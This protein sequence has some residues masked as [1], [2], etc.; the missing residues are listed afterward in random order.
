M[1]ARAPWREAVTYR[2]T[3]PHEYVVVEKDG[4]Q[5]LLAAFHHRV[6]QGEGVECRF[7]HRTQKYLFLGEYKYWALRGDD[8]VILNRALLYKDRRDFVIREGDT[9]V[10]EVIMDDNSSA[11]EVELTDDESTA[12][13]SGPE[14]RIERLE[15]REA[16][17]DEA[18]DFT[19][20]LA[21]NLDTLGWEL[22]LN[23]ELV[24]TEKAVGSFYLDILA[25][26]VDNG[27]LVAIENQLEWSDHSHLG[28]LLTY[29]AKCE[30]TAAVWIASE[31]RYEHRETINRLNQWTGNKIR[32]YGIEVRCIKI[33]DSSPAPDFRVVAAPDGWG[34]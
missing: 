14:G 19:P 18:A 28:Q 2:D 22:G 27:T 11:N 4:Q 3:W 32:W 10:R 16:W 30:A 12:A 1:I 5:E 26:D 9:G 23:L 31:F 34:W 20:W 24:E 21:Q 17:A 6:S 13:T 8:D 29:A 33:G 7:F 25:R 15:V